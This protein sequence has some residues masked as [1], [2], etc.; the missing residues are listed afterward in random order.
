VSTLLMGRPTTA[1]N[2]L[3][4]L[5]ASQQRDAVVSVDLEA[6]LLKSSTGDVFSAFC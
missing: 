6:G 3:F 2:W 4:P 5:M 1:G